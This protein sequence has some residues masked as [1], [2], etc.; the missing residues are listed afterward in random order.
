MY[1]LFPLLKNITVF[2][3]ASFCYALSVQRNGFIS[4][5][6]CFNVDLRF[7]RFF[8]LFIFLSAASSSNVVIGG[9]SSESV[10]I[11]T[12]WLLLYNSE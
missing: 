2:G 5:F 4:C 12:A 6:Q 11:V 7:S 10:C 3:D 1:L 9:S 8:Q